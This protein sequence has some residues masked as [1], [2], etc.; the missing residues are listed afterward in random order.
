MFLPYDLKN[1][2]MIWAVL[3][4]LLLAFSYGF[5]RKKKNRN[6]GL[7]RYIRNDLNST[8]ILNFTLTLSGSLY[9][10]STVYFFVYILNFIILKIFEG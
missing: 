7:P 4:V 5:F 3:I 1:M 9:E 10:V 6:L 2:L 8:L